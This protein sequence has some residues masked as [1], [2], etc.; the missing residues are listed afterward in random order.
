MISKFVNVDDFAGLPNVDWDRLFL[1]TA[2]PRRGEV[3]RR[4]PQATR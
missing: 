1:L 3:V 4:L 2:A